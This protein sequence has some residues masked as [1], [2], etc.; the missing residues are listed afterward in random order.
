M[1]ITF[2]IHP[3]SWF[4]HKDAE[5][6]LP[7]LLKHTKQVN[8]TFVTELKEEGDFLFALHY[9][10][11]VPSNL[12][13][14]HKSNIVIH[15]ADLP[16]GRGRSPVHWQVEK[17]CNDIILTMFEMGDGADNGPIYLKHTLT[18]DGT[19]LLPEIRRK[20]IETE[21]IMVDYFLQNWP[22]NPI[23][24]IGTASYFPKRT[25]ANQKL[26]PHKTIAEQ[27]DKMRVA[28]N[29][30]YP[31]WFELNNKTYKIKIE[32]FESKK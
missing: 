25:Q 21:S 18:L 28:D 27:F 20:I 5:L 31:L 2:L 19:E 8:I 7:I 15:G 23:P 16:S 14:L 10:A 4:T 24:Q 29:D 1:K 22:I 3:K 30:L 11:L 32:Y 13:N 6:F 26:D 12:F 17:G 9:P